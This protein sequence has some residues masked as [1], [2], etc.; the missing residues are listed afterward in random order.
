MNIRHFL[1]I[2]TT[3]ML[4]GAIAELAPGCRHVTSIARTERSLAEL[5][6]RIAEGTGALHPSH[7]LI[8]CDYRKR[9][10]FLEGID[11]AIE[12]HGPV[13]RALVWMH[14]TTAT[15]G[16]IDVARHLASASGATDFYHVLG[17]S[18]I[19]DLS[20]SL[21]ADRLHFDRI[22]GIRYYQIV[23]GYDEERGRRR[24]LTD[25]EICGG[26]VEAV[27]QKRERWIVGEI[28]G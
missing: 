19:A 26:V 4:A 23:L 7:T 10:M 14:G 21:D 15:N 12:L 22:E 5:D 13:D 28:G 8:P 6:R 16:S 9:S 27:E 18:S 11:E 20:A 2:G 17:S 25:E 24:W 1:T 3:G